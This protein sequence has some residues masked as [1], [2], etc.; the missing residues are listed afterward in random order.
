MNI[1]VIGGGSLGLLFAAGAAA[2][3]ASVALYTRKEE[4]ALRIAREGIEVRSAEDRPPLR[5][6]AG[7][8]AALSIERHAERTKTGEDTWVVLALKQKDLNEELIDRLKADLGAK[9]RLF[10]L[11]N[12]VGHIERLRRALPNHD[13]YAAITTEGARRSDA[14]SVLRAGQGATLFGLPGTA[15]VF[16]PQKEAAEKKLIDLFAAA[17]LTLS[18]SNE[19][20]TVMYRKLMINAVINPLTAIWKIE[21]GALLASRH[22]IETMRGIFE[23]IGHVYALAGISFEA[24]WWED[25]IG[26]CRATSR[27]RSSMLEDVTHGRSTEARWICGG[28]VDLARGFKAEAPLNRML[29][30]LIEGMKE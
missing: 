13:I 9:D 2:G 20:E 1:E 7:A 10:C 22:R 6:P 3:G 16:S 27:N 26:V 12:G 25:L 18:A 5:I 15:S 21:N 30:E 8:I 4:Q 28:I 24:G 19:I 11:Q 14:N 17:G 29:L 23:E